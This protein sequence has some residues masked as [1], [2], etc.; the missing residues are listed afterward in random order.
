MPRGKKKTSR[1]GYSVLIIFL[2]NVAILGAGYWRFTHPQARVPPPKEA[3]ML[4]PRAVAELE[5]KTLDIGAIAQP[6]VHTC[7][8]PCQSLSNGVKI[9]LL[10]YGTAWKEGETERLTSLALDTGFRG[11]DSANQKRHYNE[12]MTGRAVSKAISS[13]KLLRHEL[14]LQSKFTFSR[15]HTEGEEPYDS[16]ASIGEQVRASFRSSL[17]NFGTTY[18][19][20]YIIHGPIKR[21]GLSQEDVE[22]WLALEELYNEGQ[23]RAI[24]VSNFNYD[25]LSLL[26]NSPLLTVKPHIAQIRT[27]AH[28]GWDDRTGGVRDLCQ[29]HGILYEGYSLLTANRKALGGAPV[30]AL[31]SSRG[32]TVQ[33][34]AIR[35]ALQLGMVALTGTTDVLHMQQDLQVAQSTTSRS[36]SP[37]DMQ[38]ILDAGKRSRHP[39]GLRG[40]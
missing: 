32:E 24:G 23:V 11:I 38:V 25:Q 35:F 34:V 6:P 15:G 16:A 26:L 22:A 8:S 9:P 36:L 31:A 18:L 13:G 37:E 39:P 28:M 20:S 30:V 19:D 5:S 4:M 40:A 29:K 10:L 2:V 21:P 17:R 1:R 14:F 12:L 27:F 33:Q 3:G 7:K